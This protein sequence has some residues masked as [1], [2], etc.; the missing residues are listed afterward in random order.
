MSPLVASWRKVA[1]VWRVMLILKPIFSSS[2]WIHTAASSC[3]C[4]PM[5]TA[6]SSVTGVVTPASFISALALSRSNL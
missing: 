4:Q 2:R 1:S 3:G 6:R 5:R